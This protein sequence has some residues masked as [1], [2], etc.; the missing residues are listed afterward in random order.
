MQLIGTYVLQPVLGVKHLVLLVL[1]ENKHPRY[2][3]K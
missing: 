1:G 2:A 3:N